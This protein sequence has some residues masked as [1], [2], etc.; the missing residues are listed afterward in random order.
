MLIPFLNTFG[1]PN[2]VISAGV[3]YGIAAAIWFHQAGNFGR[4]AAAVLVALLLVVLMVVNGRTHLLDVRVSKGEKLPPEKFVA[5]NSF[6][7]VGVTTDRGYTSI[8]I[9]ADAATALAGKDWDHLSDNERRD[10]SAWR[11]R[12]SVLSPSGRENVSHRRRRRLRCRASAGIRQ[13][14]HHGCG[15]QS[16][17][18]NQDHARTVRR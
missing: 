7:R 2:T 15:D 18:R 12:V 3:F 4:R 5:W 8:V 17:H 1:G 10:L 16:H 13:P 9:D 14:R 11:P 6:S